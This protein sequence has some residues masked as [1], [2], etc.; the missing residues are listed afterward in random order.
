V[1]A[2]SGFTNGVVALFRNSDLYPDWVV[3]DS[4]PETIQPRPFYRDYSRDVPFEHT[5]YTSP[6]LVREWAAVRGMEGR[7][8]LRPM[9]FS[10]EPG[11]ELVA[12]GPAN[13]IN[14]P[15]VQ[16]DAEWRYDEPSGRYLRWS[17][18]TAHTDA[19]TGQQL[20]AANVVVLYVPQ[21]N[22][23]IIEEPHSG[24]LSIR[25]A[26]WNQE[27]PYRPAI[28]FRDGKRY[29]GI[30]TREERSDPVTLTDEEGNTLPFKVGSTFFEIL[31]QGEHAIDITVE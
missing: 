3:S 31:P 30:W 5:M 1:F 24:A 7:R 15:W 18:G 2:N 23:D 17:D 8:E 4:L 29:D 12:S 22:T 6:A 16:L 10:E 13:T 26:L 25:W 19:L 27:N 9:V 11:P 20:G 21:W 28:L 14:I